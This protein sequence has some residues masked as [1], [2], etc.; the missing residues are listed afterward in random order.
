M[1]I[2]TLELPVWVDVVEIRFIC[3]VI[4]FHTSP[5]LYHLHLKAL[6]L[7]RFEVTL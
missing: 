4:L 5:A 3:K 1:L 2:E 7:N 6:I